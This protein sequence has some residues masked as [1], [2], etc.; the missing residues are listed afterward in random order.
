LQPFTL[1]IH[2]SVC[3]FLSFELDTSIYCILLNLSS[4]NTCLMKEGSNG[5]G[6]QILGSLELSLTL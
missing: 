2:F 4:Q 3:I 6:I 5:T 1:I